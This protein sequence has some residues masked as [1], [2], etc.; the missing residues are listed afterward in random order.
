MSIGHFADDGRLDGGADG[1]KPRDLHLDAGRLRAIRAIRRRGWVGGGLVATVLTDW[2]GHN[3][4]LQTVAH[5]AALPLA[6]IFGLDFAQAGVIRCWNFFRGRVLIV[7]FREHGQREHRRGQDPVKWVHDR[8][9][10]RE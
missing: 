4:V 3:P 7:D 9:D 1:D 5:Y 8:P 6:I 10:Q 2:F